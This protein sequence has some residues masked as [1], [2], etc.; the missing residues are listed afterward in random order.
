MKILFL[1]TWYPEPADN[2]SKIRTFHMLRYLATRHEV[3][4]A[5]FSFGTA[6]PQSGVLPEV[7]RAIHVVELDPFA[8]NQAPGWQR[9]TA[10]QPTFTRAVPAMMELVKGLYAETQF[11]L[12]IASTVVMAVYALEAPADVVKV[13]EEHNSH[14]AWAR[15]GVLAER[16][17]WKRLHRRATALK[18]ARY[19]AAAYSRFDLVAMVSER[20]A[21]VTRSLLPRGRPPVAVVSNGVD[22]EHC[23]FVSVPRTPGMLIYNG[24]LSYGPNLDAMR[25]FLRTIYPRIRRAAPEVTLTITGSLHGVDLSELPLDDSVQLTGFVE[26]IRVPVGQAALCVVPLRRGGGSRLKVLEAMALGTPVVA[27]SKGVEGL[28]VTADEHVLVRDD[29]AGFAAAVITLLQDDQQRAE[30]ATRARALVESRYDW[31]TG[32]YPD[33]TALLMSQVAGSAQEFTPRSLQC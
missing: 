25:H 29:D 31:A 21:A 14:T 20:D 3:T 23:R 2:G 6:R 4:L 27:T 22:C 9:F 13:I 12:V 26:D 17:M 7:C 1:A 10:A 15:E 18:M 32:I 30:L 11:D 24:G 19:E 8:T 16:S 33:F 28:A 5:A